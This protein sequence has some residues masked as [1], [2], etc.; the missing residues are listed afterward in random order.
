MEEVSNG[1]IVTDIS[2][3]PNVLVFRVKKIGRL[4][5]KDKGSTILRYAGKFLPFDAA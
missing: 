3:D 2:N 4:D 5:P 1:L